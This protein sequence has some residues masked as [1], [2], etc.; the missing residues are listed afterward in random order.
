MGDLAA[1]ARGTAVE[2]YEL[3]G[4]RLLR[5]LEHGAP[6]TA[7]AVADSGRA[8]VSGALDGSVWSHDGVDQC[9]DR[10]I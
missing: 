1:I 9:V 3:P 6:V 2:V 8:I 7:I 4:G 10:L 5:T